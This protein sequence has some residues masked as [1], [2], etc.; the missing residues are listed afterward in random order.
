[1]IKEGLRTFKCDISVYQIEW[2]SI[3]ISWEENDLLLEV[4]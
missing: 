3:A 1:M 2:R 4:S